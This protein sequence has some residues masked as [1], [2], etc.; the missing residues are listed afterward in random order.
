MTDE[1]K[2]V[3]AID[4][5]TWSDGRLRLEGHA[6]VRHLDAS[7]ED[8]SRIRI[9]L[10]AANRRGL[11]RVPVRRVRRPDVTAGSRQSN[12]SYDW[13]GFVAEIDPSALRMFGRWRDVDWVPCVEIVNRGLRRRSTFVGPRL[14]GRQWPRDRE[15]APGVL[16]QG[17]TGRN[18]FVIQ[19]RRTPAA[20]VGCH[21]E[22]G[23]LWLDG[24]SR[25]P[26]GDEPRVTAVPRVGR[27][28]VLGPVEPVG[29]EGFRARLPVAG[30]ARRQ[31]DWEITLSE[32][33]A[34]TWTRNRR[35]RPSPS[36]A[37]NW[38]S[39]GRGAAPCGSSPAASSSPS[40]RC[41]GRPRAPSAWRARARTGSGGRTRWS[42]GGGGR[43][44][45]TPS[46][47]TGRTT[48]SRRCSRPRACRCSVCRARWSRAAGTS[49]PRSEGRSSRWS[50]AAIRSATCPS[51]SRRVCTGSPSVPRRPTSCSCASRRPWTTTSAAPTRRAAYGP[52][53]T[54]AT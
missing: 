28:T 11:M 45:N 34:R 35:V 6:Y 23:E 30:L 47:C 46:G 18:R 50:S 12:V 17:V 32:G 41:R 44:R 15:C 3:A 21:L 14:T 31:G 40:T 2:P 5:A 13:S 42:S 33:S 36:P 19:V 38:R 39:P 29:A 4:R 8:G 51:R 20:V 24:W 27:A 52:G 37:G 16:V 43:A 10:V 25:V 49:S 26:F 53:T 7:S 48:G 54:G 9:W 1:L 22:G